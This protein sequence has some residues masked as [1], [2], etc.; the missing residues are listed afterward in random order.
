[1]TKL[2]PGREPAPDEWDP[3]DPGT[4]A[5]LLRDLS[6]PWCIAGGWSIDLFL[7]RQ[8]REHSDIEIVIPETSIG[9]VTDALPDHEFTVCEY[10]TFVREPGAGVWR[11][12]VMRDPHD[13][14]TW[15]WRINKAICMPYSDLIQRTDGGIPYQRP[16]V[17]L[18]Y[19]AGSMRLKDEADLEVAGKHL[20]A[21]GRAWLRKAISATWGQ[22]HR[23][24]IGDWLRTTCDEDET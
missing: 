16:E 14:G 6:V 20:S 3:W 21:T 9:R 1:M 23:W 12:D 7:G 22:N 11:L 15:M 13:G 4:V 2:L 17:S 24:L 18:L 19:K 5:D 10:H 8:T